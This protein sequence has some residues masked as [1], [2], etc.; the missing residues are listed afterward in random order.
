MPAGFK[1]LNA[2]RAI[3]R[4]H[5]LGAVALKGSDVR[6]SC[7]TFQADSQQDA[8][9]LINNAFWKGQNWFVF[10]CRAPS[11]NMDNV[12]R[13]VIDV[14][15]NE[16]FG[17]TG[18]VR[19]DD[20]DSSIRSRFQGSSPIPVPAHLNSAPACAPVRHIQRHCL[21]FCLDAGFRSIR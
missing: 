3:L 17:R 7:F 14:R 15:A 18:R 4:E 5:C 12:G 1:C 10:H 13:Q 6:C 9:G 16:C 21:T 2:G 19:S 11:V 8:P 20:A